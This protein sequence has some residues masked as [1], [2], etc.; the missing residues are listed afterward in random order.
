MGMFYVYSTLDN[1]ELYSIVDFKNAYIGW[2]QKEYEPYV[3]TQVVKEEV[4]MVHDIYDYI[5]YVEILPNKYKIYF[6]H[7]HE[8]VEMPQSVAEEWLFVHGYNRTK[9]YI[10]KECYFCLDY[11]INGVENFCKAVAHNKAE[12]YFLKG[13][14]GNE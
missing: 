9:N 7:N 5:M 1:Y 14:S 2:E 12:Q 8:S 13:Y 6:G 11:A 3:E 10:L 4:D